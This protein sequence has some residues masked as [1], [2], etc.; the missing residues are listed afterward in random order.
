MDSAID[1]LYQ[2]PLAFKWTIYNMWHAS[3]YKRVYYDLISDVMVLKVIT[4]ENTF[5]QVTQEQSNI[6]MLENLPC[7]LPALLLSQ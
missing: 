5:V 7:S 2:D 3:N 1:V 4:E 6:D